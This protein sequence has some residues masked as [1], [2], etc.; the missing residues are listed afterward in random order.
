MTTSPECNM[1]GGDRNEKRWDAYKK[2]EER[3]GGGRGGTND[4]LYL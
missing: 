1:P 4:G 2:G 3:D